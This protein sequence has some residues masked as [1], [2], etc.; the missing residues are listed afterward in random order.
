MILILPLKLIQSIIS[1]IIVYNL[2]TEGVV[3]IALK[4]V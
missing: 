4:I 1:L 2:K 3:V